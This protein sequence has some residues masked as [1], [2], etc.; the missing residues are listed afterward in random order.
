MS[1]PKIMG[2]SASYLHKLC[3]R[4]IRPVGLYA[5]GMWYPFFFDTS[6]SKLETVNNSPASII[7]GL[8]GGSFSIPAC[9]EAGFPAIKIVAEVE[10][11]NTNQKLQTQTKIEKLVGLRERWRSRSMF[12]TSKT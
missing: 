5:A 1:V 9:T 3:L 2:L 6:S 12:V 10:S 7:A 8:S 4:Y 11:D